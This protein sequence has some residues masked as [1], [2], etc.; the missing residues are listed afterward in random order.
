MRYLVLVFTFVAVSGTAHAQRCLAY[1]PQSVTLEGRIF[2]KDFP[3][4]PNFESSA[5]GDERMRYWIL[6]L[7][8]PV[9]VD[10]S[11]N[12]VNVAEDHVREIQLAFEDDAFYK[13][14]RRVVARGQRFRVAG[15]LF[16]QF[17]G[18]HVRKILIIVKSL[19]P[20]PG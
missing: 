9:C 19:E 2:R 17:S 18:H 11:T 7:D 1:E 16:H 4:P 10:R 13:K 15:S 5:R 20:L 8:S 6:R 12:E 3:G 14:Y